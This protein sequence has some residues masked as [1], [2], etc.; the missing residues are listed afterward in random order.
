M[1]VHNG[2]RDRMR[3]RYKEEGLDG[4]REHE[5]LEMLLYYCIAQK[6]TNEMA[7]HLINKA[8][9]FS[10]VFDLPM[11]EIKSIT[12]LKDNAATFIKFLGAFSKYYAGQCADRKSVV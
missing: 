8:G 10:R 4:F 6:D 11:N 7:H 2:H 12:G 3:Q 9:S 5:V 1:S